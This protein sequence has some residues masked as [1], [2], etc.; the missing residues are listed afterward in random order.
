MKTLF[1]IIGIAATLVSCKPAQMTVPSRFAA[2]A[3][4][5][6]VKGLNVFHRRIS[7]GNYHT[8]KVKR[9]W[10]ISSKRYD[11]K[12]KVTTED[13]VAALFGL[14]RQRFT[15]HER[16]KFQYTLSDNNLVAEI[17]GLESSS[18]EELAIKT[19]NRWLGDTYRVL[20]S[21][22]SFSAV[23]LPQTAK[24]ENPWQLIMYKNY[25]R[26]LDTARRIFDLPYNEE[27][28]FAT[29]GKDT[30][31]I[32]HIYLKH[33]TSSSGREGTYPFK[34]PAGYELRIDD[35]VV[36]IVDTMF[37]SIWLY[38]DL[39]AETKLILS[40]ISSSILLRR[41]ESVN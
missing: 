31:T 34:I 18:G 14:D 2:E 6:K 32:R 17:F 19:H 15:T 33:F 8:S 30:I 24:E 39:D 23:I 16:S 12:Y 10:G 36:G 27:G 7:F 9:G 29:N 3:T 41:S 37:D 40:S 26:N 35:G 11:K 13:R 22:Y 28:G 4:E 5:M 38:N 21:Q 1:Y 20:N 25:D